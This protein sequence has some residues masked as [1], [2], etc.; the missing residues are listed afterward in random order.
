MSRFNLFARWSLVFG[1]LGVF[2]LYSLSAYNFL[3][4]DKAYAA[5]L[6]SDENAK[7]FANE[8][9]FVVLDDAPGASAGL[10]NRTQVICAI[11]QEQLSSLQAD[12]STEVSTVDIGDRTVDVAKVEQTQGV[13][14]KQI[15]A[16]LDINVNG[17]KCK[18][19]QHNKFFMIF[20]TPG[21]S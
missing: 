17:P 6:S 19:V 21:V 3:H 15:Y 20:L 16:S 13:H 2:S 12:Y 5:T 7:V 8:D 1:V 10:H 11:N 4:S 14:K 18:V 9:N